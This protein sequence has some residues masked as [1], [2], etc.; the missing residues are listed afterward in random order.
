[1][2]DYRANIKLPQD[3]FDKLKADKPDGVTWKYYLVELRTMD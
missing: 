3:A 1:M 2:T